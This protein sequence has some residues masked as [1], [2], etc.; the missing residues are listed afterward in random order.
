[1]AAGT[2]M[3]P[4]D[5]YNPSSAKSEKIPKFDKKGG[6]TKTQAKI[7]ATFPF[8]RGS[9]VSHLRRSLAY[10]DPFNNGFEDAAFGFKG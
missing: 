8:R 5:T 9:F 6:A 1:M 4:H 3:H 2:I 10:G 7:M